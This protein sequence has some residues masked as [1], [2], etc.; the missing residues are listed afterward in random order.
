[1]KSLKKSLWLAAVAVLAAAAMTAVACGGDDDDDD[2]GGTGGDND[3]P[4]VIAR[5][6]D[7]NSLDP[8]RAYCDTCQIYLTATYSTL[9]GL[10]PKDNQT[11]IPRVAEKWEGNPDRTQYTFHLNKN[12][13]F[14]D[15]TPL[16]SADVKWSFERLA[17]VKGSA[18]YFMDGITS[19]ETPDPQTLIVKLAAP[20]SAFLA[21]VNAPYAGITNSKLAAANGAT[22]GSDADTSD[23]A[24][25]W[26]LKNSAGSGPYTLVNYAEGDEIRL[27]RNE[28]Y[29]GDKPAL[30]EVIIKQVKD[31]VTQR[32][33]LETG[34]ADIAMQ[35]DP[36]TAKKVNNKSV[37]IKEVPSFNFVYIALSP[38]AKDTKIDLNAN[39]REAVRAALDY[40]GLI[41]VTLGGGGKKQAAPIPNGFLGTKNLPL[42][43]RD[44]AKAKQLMKDGGQPNGFEIDAIYPNVNVYGVD[45]NTM[46]Q[47]VQTDL[48]EI[49]IKLKL[50]P[51]EFS[52]FVAKI[53]GD[54]IP[55]S[56]IYFA[57]D[58][59]DPIQYVQYFGM[60][61]GAPW[62]ARA[63]GADSPL[64]NQAEVD[65][66]AKALATSDDEEREKLYE[67]IG[68][69]MIKDAIILPIVN[70]NL[71]LAYRS[72]IDGMHYSACCNLEVA[73]LKR[74]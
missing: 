62:S 56:A 60:V 63:G 59:T 58:H 11:F 70:P 5:D 8:A 55:I 38:G 2:D 46:M 39:I 74:K 3:T 48:A 26:F 71:E 44:L 49:D 15:G 50:Q 14:A 10:D 57:P 61:P 42:P 29:W 37:V 66:A 22:N 45:F 40:D 65:L 54:G 53:R 12:A 25:E 67:S 36:D 68:K 41:Q 30:K 13:K 72:N 20:D 43:E 23:K 32:Q 21:K 73:L 24:E 27:L 47:K 4:L 18:A 52:V 28:N 34:D 6:M 31:A 1:M 7:I 19:M 51:V 9:I 17:N 64:V 16:T 33:Q 35:L 69:E